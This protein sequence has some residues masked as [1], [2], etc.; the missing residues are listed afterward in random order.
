MAGRYN[1][2]GRQIWVK[3]KV[4]VYGRCKAARMQE[5]ARV[6]ASTHTEMS[7]VRLDRCVT[8]GM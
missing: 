5:L 6:F 3:Q 8:V 1:D 4:T 7:A 2:A